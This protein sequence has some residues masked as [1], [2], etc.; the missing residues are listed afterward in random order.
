MFISDCMSRHPI[1][2]PPTLPAAE[3]QRILTENHIRHLPV[4][5]GNRTLAGLVTRQQLLLRAD[6]IGSLSMWEIARYLADLQVSQVM[7]RARDVA[8]I[9]AENVIEDASQ[10]MA[11]RKVGCLPVI[12]AAGAVIGIVT[13]NDL[14]RAYQEMLGSGNKGVRATIRIPDRTGELAKLTGLIAERKWSIQG[15]GT[16]PTRR[17]SG[18]HDVVIKIGAASMGE[19]TEA[20]AT[21]PECT[22]VD[23][24][25]NNGV[26]E[27]QRRV[28][29]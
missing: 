10:I 2:V 17:T 25:S 6:A 15:I 24:R 7:V 28:A 4:I 27:N 23:V 5:D 19:V 16:F 20:L 8:T 29:V 3:A 1:L 26:S 9:R 22:V 21:L 12:D 13:E 11:E 18:F 14:L